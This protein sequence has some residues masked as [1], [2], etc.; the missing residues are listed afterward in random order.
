MAKNKLNYLMVW[1]K[2]YDELS[3]ELKEYA[4]IRGII[5]ESGHHNFDY[6]I[7]PEKYRKNHPDFFAVTAENKRRQLA[8]MPEVSR[9]L[10]TTNPALRT[11]LLNSLLRYRKEHPE[12][13]GI[14]YMDDIAAM[15]G[16]TALMKSGRRDVI[17]TG[18]NDDA[19]AGH[20]PYPITTVRHDIGKIVTLLVE[21]AVSRDQAQILVMPEIIIRQ[22]K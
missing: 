7:P 10:C 19:A 11:E 2:Y 17:V 6:L 16:A 5:I 13:K 1:M 9:Q 20:F 4:A 21:K 8:G 14:A 18:F 12:I 15:G 3:A 22:I